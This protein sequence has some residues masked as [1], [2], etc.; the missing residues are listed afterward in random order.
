LKPPPEGPVDPVSDVQ[1][2]RPVRHKCAKNR[3]DCRVIE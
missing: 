3:S 1:H 2:N